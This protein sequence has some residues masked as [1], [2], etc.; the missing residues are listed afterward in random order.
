MNQE[1]YSALDPYGKALLDYLH[2]NKSGILVEEFRSGEK[3]SIPVSVFFRTPNEFYPT[4]Q[5][6]KFC[7]GNVLVVGAGTGVH[8]LEL[9]NKGFNCTAI[10]VCSQ[11]VEVMKQR[12]VKKIINLDFFELKNHLFDTVLILGHNIGICKNLYGI[13]NFFNH[14]KSLLNDDGQ[15]IINSVDDSKSEKNLSLTDYPGELE[16]RLSY[17]GNIGKWMN[18]L[19]ID[20]E[21]LRL[22]ALENQWSA[23]KLIE[24]ENG[25][26]MALLKLEK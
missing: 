18:W 5:F 14:V 9:Q 3:L 8:A 2:G 13:Q 10:E 26:F 4:E 22:K 6:L 24:T 21:T 19:H 11:A 20:F 15:L 25:E 12:G 7:K 17:K 1:K 23:K 16:F